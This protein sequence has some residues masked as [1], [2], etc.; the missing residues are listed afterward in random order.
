MSQ[1]TQPIPTTISVGNGKIKNHHYDRYAIVYVRQSTLQQV[2]R[3]SESTKLQYALVDKARE[4]GWVQEQILVI[5]EDLG[6]SGASAEGRPGFQRLV[7]EVGLDR[8]GLVLGIEISR[9]AR[10]C[11]DWYQLLEVCALFRTL[12]GDADGI[13]DPAFYN[14]RLLLGLKGTMSEAELHILKQRMI[15]GKRAKARRGELGMQLPIGYLQR[16]SGDVVKDPDEQAQSVILMIFDL[17]D[18]YSTLHAVLKY[19]VKNQ[20]Q[21]PHRERSGI[22]K[23]DLVW[24]RP[25]R[26]TLGGILHHPIYAGAYVY[27]RRV[28]DP[29]K[30]KSGRP[31]TGRIVVKPEECAV[32]IR[33]KRPAYITWERYERNQRQLASNT[34]QGIGVPRQGHSL[35]A[36]ILICGRCGLRMSTQYTNNGN[37]LRYN[38]G[39]AKVNYGGE[40]CQSLIGNPLDDLISE[41]ILEALKPSS[42]EISLSVSEDIEKERKTLVV[43]WENKLERAQYE[44]ERAYR[45]YNAT[46]PENRL[47]ARTLEKK[48][49]ELLSAEKKLKQE[50]AEFQSKRPVTL[51]EFDREKIRNLASD[52]PSLWNS[53]STTVQER[54]EI[55]RL[56]IERVLVTIHEKSE[57]VL[58]EI[59]WS[60]GYKTSTQL[61]R[62]VAKLEQLTYYRDL[63]DRA[64]HLRR[65]GKTMNHIAKVLNHEGWRLPKQKAN[66]TGER[67]SH[68]LASAGLVSTKKIRSTKII[69]FENELTLRE[70]S[71]KTLIPEPTLYKWMRKGLLKARRAAN[72]DDAP[73]WL[74]DANDEELTKLEALKNQPKEWIFRSRVKRVE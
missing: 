50:Y 62:P 57:K 17:F 25:N 61:I 14:D 3:H 35:L 10:S 44:V 69:R 16:P 47:V 48:W 70:L 2:E 55:I 72:G 65:E 11:R 15:E 52:I 33:D 30:K 12:I 28:T 37:K 8:V 34:A 31:S 23:G 40:G 36:G 22:S 41:Q 49:E 6:R 74:I 63:L 19:L 45:Q 53:S 21:L 26:M 38:C 4:Q 24:R 60:G 7:A 27:G 71:Q 73:M 5:D 9:L 43:H 64:L 67:V 32:L 18:R 54:Q 46:E 29:R 13:Y 58:V 68:L 39:N 1:E 51:S 20:I 59:H 42:L 66:I 56:L